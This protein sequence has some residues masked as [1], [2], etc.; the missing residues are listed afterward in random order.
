MG[1]AAG[2]SDMDNDEDGGGDAAAVALEG[3]AELGRKALACCRKDA[4]ITRRQLILNI[5]V[6]LR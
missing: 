2:F 1:R 6:D 4:L 3:N 5:S